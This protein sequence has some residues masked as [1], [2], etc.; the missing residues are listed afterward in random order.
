MEN[1][2]TRI[3]INL[4]SREIEFEGS[5]TFI[6]RYQSV[7]DEFINKIKQEPIKAPKVTNTA[8]EDLVKNNSTENNKASNF[9]NSQPENQLPA[10]FGEYYS[11]FPKNLKVV[12][13]IILAAFFL[14][15]KSDDGLFII[16]D[17]ADLLLEQNVQ[18]TN[19]NAFINSLMRSGKIFR[20]AGKYKLTE[21][22]IDDIDSLMTNI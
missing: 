16:K 13:K 5:E 15:T 18:V 7:I 17:T 6:E 12:D 1:I 14:Q 22:A 11:K 21:K 19:A 3:R 4:N 20:H 8:R 9:L 10:T 2:S